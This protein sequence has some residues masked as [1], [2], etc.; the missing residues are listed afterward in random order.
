MDSDRLDYNRRRRPSGAHGFVQSQGHLFPQTIPGDYHAG[1]GRIVLVTEIA[2]VVDAHNCDVPRNG[3]GVTAAERPE[4]VGR[5]VLMEEDPQRLGLH[6]Q[7]VRQTL[8]CLFRGKGTWSARPVGRLSAATVQDHRQAHGLGMAHKSGFP[9][10]PDPR[11]LRAAPT[12]HRDVPE[13]HVVEMSSRHPTDLFLIGPNGADTVPACRRRV[14]ADDPEIVPARPI[15]TI[16]CPSQHAGQGKRTFSFQHTNLRRPRAR[17]NGQQAPSQPVTSNVR[18]PPR[19]QLFKLRAWETGQH[20]AGNR[21]IH[22]RIRIIQ[23]IEEQASNP[24]RA[25]S[26]A[27]VSTDSTGSRPMVRSSL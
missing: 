21:I 18:F 10:K 26:E 23:T 25:A 15:D 17:V 5:P 3:E 2:I 1:Q 19:P 20:D 6:P 24:G 16:P 22:A 27:E 9:D 12:N 4:P 14:V 11:A 13:A 7:P 8:L